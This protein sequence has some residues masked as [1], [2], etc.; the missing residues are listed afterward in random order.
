MSIEWLVVAVSAVCCALIALLW[1]QTLTLG[2][3][4]GINTRARDRERHDFHQLLERLLEKRDTPDSYR[5][6]E[7]HRTE[8]LRLNQ[9]DAHVEENAETPPRP[10]ERQ[11]EEQCCSPDEYVN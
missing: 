3:L 7:L 11:E 8:R 9:I 2:R 5:T 4:A 6:S 10:V 1:R